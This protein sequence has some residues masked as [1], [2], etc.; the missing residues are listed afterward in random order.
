MDSQR[1]KFLNLKNPPARLNA[2]E[3][4]WY[5]GFAP[6]DIPVLVSH[7]LLKP[8]GHPAS[9]SVKFFAFVTLVELRNDPKWLARA[10]DTMIQHWRGKNG[11]KPKND[12]RFVSSSNLAT[13]VTDGS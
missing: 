12:V 3:A 2:E 4:A 13:H 11:I 1:E 9:H 10:T 5:L 8:L 6:H 7:G